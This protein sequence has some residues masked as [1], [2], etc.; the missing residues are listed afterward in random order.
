MHNTNKIQEGLESLNRMRLMMGY[1]MSKTLNENNLLIFEADVENTQKIQ[2]KT[3][4]KNT[5]LKDGVKLTWNIINRDTKKTLKIERVDISAPDGVNS[6]NWNCADTN[7]TKKRVSVI[8]FTNVN[9]NPNYQ[10]IVTLG[11]FFGADDYYSTQP[12]AQKLFNFKLIITTSEGQITTS[13]R[14]GD[15]NIE[16]GVAKQQREVMEKI[17]QRQTPNWGAKVPEGFSPFSYE[18]FITELYNRLSNRY[19]SQGQNCNYPG[20]YK[21]YIFIDPILS[22]KFTQPGNPNTSENDKFCNSQ[23]KSLIEKYYDEKFPKGVTPED[24]EEFNQA[25]SSSSSELNRFK[26]QHMVQRNREP[27]DM[28][29]DEKRLSPEL[30]K[31]YKELVGKIG[32]LKST[33]GYDDRNS[34]DKFWEEYG[35]WV[36]VGVGVLTAIAS[37]GASSPAVAGL[38]AE[39]IGTEAASVIS[40]LKTAERFS[41]LADVYMNASVGTYQLGKGDTKEAMLSFFFAGLPKIHKLYSKVGELFG[42]PSVDIATSLAN[43]IGQVS[44]KNKDEINA[45]ITTLSKEEAIY[46]KKALKLNQGDWKKIW[47]LVDADM[48]KSLQIP[49]TKKVSTGSKG[50]GKFLGTAA[51]DFSVITTSQKLYEVAVNQINKYCKNCMTTEEEKRKAKTYLDSITPIQRTNLD[52]FLNMIQQK[53]EDDVAKGEKMKLAVTGVID[54]IVTDWAKDKQDKKALDKAQ[55]VLEMLRKEKESKSFQ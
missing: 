27:F 33:Y 20:Y 44:L 40:A 32:G 47:E 6:K 46:F 55:A 37:F 3:P 2:V 31:K 15:V 1:D 25:Y 10:G 22:N 13:L 17:N 18:N 36:Q 51:V 30:Q 29:F 8:S 52:S 45:F 38:I 4:D 19:S 35:I 24:K 26:R 5:Y 53:E 12:G 41:I 9:I 11:I 23:F 28:Y 14:G 42:T 54:K 39:V 21:K 49:I 43:R 34:F 50:V 16:S 7:C 48:K